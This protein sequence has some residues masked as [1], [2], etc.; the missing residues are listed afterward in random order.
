MAAVLYVT[1]QSSALLINN[2]VIKNCYSKEGDAVLANLAKQLIVDQ[3]TFTGNGQTDLKVQQTPTKV[4]N[5]S[6]SYSPKSSVYVTSS[7][8][9]LINNTFFDGY[10]E[11]IPEN[12]NALYCDC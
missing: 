4:W 2:T 10:Y 7:T 1:G 3:V 11:Y 12:G 5:S 9:E 8:I 6:F